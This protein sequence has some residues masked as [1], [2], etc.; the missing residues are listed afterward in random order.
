MVWEN[1]DGGNGAFRPSVEVGAEGK[2]ITRR[3]TVGF[4]REEAG[5]KVYQN[6]EGLGLDVKPRSKDVSRRGQE[7][8]V[9]RRYAPSRRSAWAAF[10]QLL[11][12]CIES[13]GRSGGDSMISDCGV[14][15]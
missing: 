13:N 9:E 15:R 2:N 11:S 7:Q 14:V 12:T 4:D 8:G 1:G 6:A 5:A 10:L 3:W